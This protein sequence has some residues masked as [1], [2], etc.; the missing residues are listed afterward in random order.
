MDFIVL[1]L[2][3]QTLYLYIEII[4]I[5]FTRLISLAVPQQQEY[6]YL[7]TKKDQFLQCFKLFTM[8]SF[9]IFIRDVQLMLLDILFSN[10][11]LFT[12]Y[13]ISQL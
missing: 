7:P 6:I 3:L 13:A 8:Q 2:S 12:S 11:F 9:T 4:I 10:D 1:V 5:C